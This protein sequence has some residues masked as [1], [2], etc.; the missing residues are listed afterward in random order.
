[1]L[2]LIPG[3]R[4]Y[5]QIVCILCGSLADLVRAKNKFVST[6]CNVGSNPGIRVLY[7]DYLIKIYLFF[8]KIRE[9]CLRVIRTRLLGL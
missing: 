3:L 7:F 8:T 6:Q 4:R 5:F 2:V 1:M 9:G